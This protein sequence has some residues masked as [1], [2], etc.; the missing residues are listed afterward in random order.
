MAVAKS[1]WVLSMGAVILLVGATVF[2][3]HTY[4]PE[5]FELPVS[6]VGTEEYRVFSAFLNDFLQREQQ[7]GNY[8]KSEKLKIVNETFVRHDPGAVIPLD[9]VSLG[10]EQMGRDFYR[11]NRKR[12]SL[13][14][15]FQTTVKVELVSNGYAEKVS[16]N[17]FDPKTRDTADSPGVFALSRPGFNGD[18]SEAILYYWLRCGGVCG[19][20]GWVLLK[21]VDDTWHIERFGTGLIK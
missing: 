9:V 13:R 7:H 4:R 2:L 12:F 1:R 8:Q 11:K 15:E 20:S 19:Q 10:S 6:D 18:H 16:W 5:W 21:K 3:I 17:G 14:D